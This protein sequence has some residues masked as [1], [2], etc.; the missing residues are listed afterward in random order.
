MGKRNVSVIPSQ[1]H[2]PHQRKFPVEIAGN[3]T[4]KTNAHP[5]NDHHDGAQSL[6]E[7]PQRDQQYSGGM[8]FHS[9]TNGR[10]LP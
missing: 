4:I 2:V 7:V 5:L 1:V 9:K 6:T 8:L 10:N 3:H